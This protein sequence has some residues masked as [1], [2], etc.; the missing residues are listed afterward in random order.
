MC[1]IEKKVAKPHPN[2]IFERER[3]EFKV[4]KTSD[5]RS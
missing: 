4:V 3:C 5:W 1:A 2:Y